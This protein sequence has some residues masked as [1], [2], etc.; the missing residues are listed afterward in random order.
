MSLSGSYQCRRGTSPLRER[1][2][3]SRLYVLTHH[4][5]G[6]KPLAALGA[7]VRRVLLVAGM[8]ELRALVSRVVSLS[9]SLVILYMARALYRLQL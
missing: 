4:H 6:Y 3:A 9:C 2:D 5:K 1:P 8:R 7:S